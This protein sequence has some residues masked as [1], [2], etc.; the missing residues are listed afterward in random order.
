MARLDFMH[1]QLRD[2]SRSSSNEATSSKD[3]FELFRFTQVLF[4]NKERIY[5]MANIL[6]VVI[7][8]IGI[9]RQRNEILLDM[10]VLLTFIFIFP[11][12]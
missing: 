5:S 7:S 10:A 8:W 3:D 6:G 11:D 12:S 9:H 2:F 1:R 4:L